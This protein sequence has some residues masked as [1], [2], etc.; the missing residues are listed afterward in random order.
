MSPL[1]GDCSVKSVLYFQE[2]KGVPQERRYIDFLD[3]LLTAKDEEGRGLTRIDIRNEVD[4]FLFEGIIDKPRKT[5]RGIELP[6]QSKHF[7]GVLL[8]IFRTIRGIS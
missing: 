7:A 4:T 3:I 8:F 5:F 2:Q 1:S 6:V